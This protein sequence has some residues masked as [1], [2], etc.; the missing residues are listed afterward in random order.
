MRAEIRVLGIVQGV[1]FRPFIYRLAVSRGLKGYVRNRGDAG[2]EIVVEGS[3][4]AVKDFISKIEVE[5]PATARISRLEVKYG[6]DKGEFK[7]FK[8]L[9]SIEK[10]E[11]VGSIIP[12]DVAIC[13]Q[14]LREF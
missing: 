14:C 3:E 8:I 10:R 7:D 11:A 4:E 6:V 2:V 1:G 9:E 5:K 13:D 12:P